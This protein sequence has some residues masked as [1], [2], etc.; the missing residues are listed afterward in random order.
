M[1]ALETFIAF[2]YFFFF[3]VFSG[4]FKYDTPR[5]CP[6]SF[7]NPLMRPVRKDWWIFLSFVLSARFRWAAL[8]GTPSLHAGVKPLYRVWDGRSGRAECSVDFYFSS[9]HRRNTCWTRWRHHQSAQPQHSC[10]WD[11]GAFR[12]NPDRTRV[13]VTVKT[14]L[15]TRTIVNEALNRNITD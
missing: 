13:S 11:H 1:N 12:Y 4:I 2:M 3:K 14:I 9:F 15:V 8:R 6:L 5:T 7:H 10:K